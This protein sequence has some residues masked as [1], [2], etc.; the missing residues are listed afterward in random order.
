[1]ENDASSHATRLIASLMEA[2]PEDRLTTKQVL[3]A[4]WFNA[5]MEKEK[6]DI[7]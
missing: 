2:Q 5:D 4:P 3:K 1:M 7:F 6:E